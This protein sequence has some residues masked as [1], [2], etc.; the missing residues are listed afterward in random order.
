MLHGRN[1]LGTMKNR[2]GRGFAT[3]SAGP[4]Q[5]FCQGV[6]IRAFPEF[7]V[8]DFRKTVYN[9][10]SWGGERKHAI[11]QDAGNR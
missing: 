1:R 10:L 8:D 11:Y 3:G 9:S 2:L 6:Q 7:S 4:W 5:D